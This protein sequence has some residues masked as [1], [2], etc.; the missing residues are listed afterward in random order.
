MII[1]DLNVNIHVVVHQVNRAAVQ[2]TPVVFSQ[3][4]RPQGGSSSSL[5]HRLFFIISSSSSSHVHL[6]FIVCVFLCQLIIIDLFSSGTLI[7]GPSTIINKSHLNLTA[8]A[9]QRKLSDPGG[10]T[11]R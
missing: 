7:R 6:L 9:N 3:P 4:L 2:R 5:L 10:G 11:F 8:Q 1:Y